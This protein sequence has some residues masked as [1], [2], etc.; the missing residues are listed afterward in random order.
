MDHEEKKQNLKILSE[1]ISA[2]QNKRTMC[3]TKKKES[4]SKLT[5]QYSNN[6][7]QI[8]SL[9]STLETKESIHNAKIQK[10]QKK[11]SKL[12][13]NISLIQSQIF[14]IKNKNNNNN[15]QTIQSLIA[16]KHS[17]QSLLA[18]YQNNGHHHH[19]HHHQHE[20][21]VYNERKMMLEEE[22]RSTESTLISLTSKI[23]SHSEFVMNLLKSKSVL[24]SSL[25][26]LNEIP[27][28]PSI[29][30]LSSIDYSKLGEYI[31]TYGK[32]EL[33][34]TISKECFINDISLK[35]CLDEVIA[36]IIQLTK[37][38][39]PRNLLDYL[40]IAIGRLITYEKIL[41]SRM[42]FLNESNDNTFKEANGNNID[43]RR[44]KKQRI[45]KEIEK[46]NKEIEKK[47]KDKNDNNQYLM[48]ME[49]DLHIMVN[50]NKTMLI[51]IENASKELLDIQKDF[52]FQ[53]NKL[54]EVNSEILSQIDLK[55]DKMIKMEEEFNRD[56]DS[57]NH[58]KINVSK[59]EI[60]SNNNTYW[61]NPNNGNQQYTP[62]FFYPITMNKNDLM[63]SE[64]IAPLLKGSTILK[65]TIV[66]VKKKVYESYSPINRNK[67]VNPLDWNFKKCY[68][69]IDDKITKLIF[70][71]LTPLEKNLEIALT[72]L[73]RIEVPII[74]KSLVF[75]KR[76]YYKL[77]KTVYLKCQNQI[78]DFIA[79]NQSKVIE[80]YNKG[81][82]SSNY[83][84]DEK[85][86]NKQYRDLLIEANCY[87]LY[88]YLKPDED[89]KIEMIFDSYD[90]FKA[91]INGFEEVINNSKAVCEIIKHFAI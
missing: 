69:V 25:E 38:I 71:K 76:L 54:K 65:R 29:N 82:K 75:I 53:I 45:N 62:E 40:L 83:D 10:K 56:I 52:L 17:L 22:Y 9:I 2:I 39:L 46:I 61:H 89:T 7:S 50:Y 44:S 78:D 3:I 30:E 16:K 84:I 13:S 20:S 63:L 33:N 19:H 43:K 37:S 18:K 14:Q 32:E 67:I 48:Q 73:S 49:N 21:I 24:S 23:E 8:E 42:K 79:N 80:L 55:K 12:S 86:L 1:H 81:N 60:K 36:Y 91:W 77:M 6:I 90:D 58:L 51:D 26:K 70:Q 31:Y 27:V 57:M 68:M 5:D 41:E 85:I 66:N 47:N 74:S 4:I 88:A 15:Q 64:K 11:L 87:M 35:Y 34:I 28:N 72:S 59:E